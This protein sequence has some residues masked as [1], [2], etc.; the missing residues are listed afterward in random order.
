MRR[1]KNGG[2][3]ARRGARRRGRDRPSTGLAVD[4]S[5]L[6]RRSRALSKVLRRRLVP[7]RGSC[8]PGRGRLL[9]VRRTPGRCHQEHGPPDRAVRGRERA[10]RACCGRRGRRDR[11]ARPGGGRGGEGLRRAEAGLPGVP[12]AR[13]RAARARPRAARGRRRSEGDLVRPDAVPR[14]RSGKIMRRLLKAREL[15]L[16]EGDVST[17]EEGA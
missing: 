3:D 12:R 4:V 17:L 6:H 14:T 1:R 8:P 11:Q 13:A 16:P 10:A 7:E 2:V 15:G 9:L 5:R